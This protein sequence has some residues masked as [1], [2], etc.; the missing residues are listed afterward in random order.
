MEREKVGEEELVGRLEGLC[1]EVQE[2]V[3]GKVDEDC[4]KTTYDSVFA[5]S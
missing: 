5:D 3:A 1:M 2:V 4:S